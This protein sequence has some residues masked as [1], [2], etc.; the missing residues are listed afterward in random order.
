[1]K[2]IIWVSLITLISCNSILSFAQSNYPNKPI[3]IIVGFSPGGS[4]DAVGRSLAE[5]LSTRLGQPVIVEN[6]A[7]AADDRQPRGGAAGPG[8]GHYRP[9]QSRHGA[10]LRQSQRHDQRVAG[11]Q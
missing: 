5:A 6:R 1:M 7:G 11:R 2:K 9:D 8:R 4:A 3:K 10:G